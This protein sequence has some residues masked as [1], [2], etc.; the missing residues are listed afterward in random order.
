MNRAIK[1]RRNEEKQTN[2]Q[3]SKH[4]NKH[5]STPDHT[6]ATTTRNIIETSIHL[7]HSSL[8]TAATGFVTCTTLLSSPKVDQNEPPE[9][10][11]LGVVA[12][13]GVVGL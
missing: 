3:A 9:A 11:E 13:G 12:C 2:R 6:I 8:S 10:S 1:Q 5:R 7:I 4:T